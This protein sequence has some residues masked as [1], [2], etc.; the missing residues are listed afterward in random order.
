MVVNDEVVDPAAPSLLRRLSPPVPGPSSSSSSDSSVYTAASEEVEGLQESASPKP[1]CV[2]QR[3]IRGR[4]RC[5]LEGRM[6]ALGFISTPDHDS[7]SSKESPSCGSGG[8]L[9]LVGGTSWE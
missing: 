2:G 3:A 9:L 4:Q 1:V 6:C 8:C 5:P 7:S